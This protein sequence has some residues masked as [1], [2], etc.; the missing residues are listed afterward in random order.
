MSFFR[1]SKTDQKFFF[2][3]P[4][5]SKKF[6]KNNKGSIVATLGITT[7]VVGISIALGGYVLNSQKLAKVVSSESES[8]LLN[9]LVLTRV[10][11][12]VASTAV[13]C[14]DATGFCYWN[15]KAQDMSPENF[16][17][18]DLDTKKKSDVLTFQAE[19]CI[20]DFTVTGVKLTDCEDKVAKVEIRIKDV[21]ELTASQSVAG[22][23]QEG[24]ISGDQAESDQDNFGI[25]M[26]V[27]STY[28]DFNQEDK[29]L[30]STGMVKRPRFLLRISTE[31]AFCQPTCQVATLSDGE[32][33]ISKPQNFCMGR[34]K[35]LNNKSEAFNFNSTAT[36]NTKALSE[37]DNTKAKI[38]FTVHN[39][40]PGYLYD[41][42]VVRDF[43]KNPL[44]TFSPN[45]VMPPSGVPVISTFDLKY[46]SSDDVFDRNKFELTANDKLQL[47]DEGMKC[48]DEKIENRKIVEDVTTIVN[49]VNMNDVDLF[50]E[51]NTLRSMGLPNGHRVEGDPFD[52]TFNYSTEVINSITASSSNPKPSGDVSYRYQF[53]AP[54][55]ALSLGTAKQNVTATSTTT[56]V[57][58]TD[59][60][61]QYQEVIILQNTGQN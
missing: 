54:R 39:D 46:D 12:A 41:Y 60:Y 55:N 25:L 53:V 10:A 59:H 27:S 20:P 9:N 44:F 52:K 42:S 15:T 45:E 48:F 26:T 35:I 61:T 32:N 21:S 58:Q 13:L 3:K 57:T 29:V 6:N 38:T 14:N 30:V 51:G 49:E 1:K 7:A 50:G 16:G 4:L 11:Q 43:I 23:K 17:F 33:L 5:K 56:D 22:A 37:F 34:V 31:A 24:I 28:K 47:V 40:G 18:S 19:I 2:L 8:R 36:M